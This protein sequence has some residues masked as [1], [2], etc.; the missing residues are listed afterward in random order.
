[1]QENHGKNIC[2]E[3]IVHLGTGD[4]EVDW[5]GCKGDSRVTLIGELRETIE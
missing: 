1:M 4:D 3:A 5:G 2:R